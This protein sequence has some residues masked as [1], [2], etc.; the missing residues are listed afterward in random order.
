MRI[1]LHLP[2]ES[3]AKITAIG[4]RQNNPETLRLVTDHP[5]SSYGI[6]VILRGKSGHQLGGREFAQLVTAFGAWIDCDS[7]KTVQRVRNA[8]AQVAT[9]LDE[10]VKVA[11]APNKE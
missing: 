5:A 4:L 6:G 8:L 3:I 9:G 7:A 11:H 10:W 1:K 2:A